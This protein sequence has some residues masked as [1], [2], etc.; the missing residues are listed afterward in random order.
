MGDRTKIKLRINKDV[1]CWY[2]LV[3]KNR[4]VKLPLL[5]PPRQSLDHK[6]ILCCPFC[7]T[8]IGVMD[9]VRFDLN[10]SSVE[11]TDSASDDFVRQSCKL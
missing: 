3:Q 2:E 9:R 8:E 5:G 10:M 4:R 1:Y 11:A 7:G 6:K